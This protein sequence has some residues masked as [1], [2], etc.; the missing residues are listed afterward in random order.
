MI[1]FNFNPTIRETNKYL[2]E[3]VEELLKKHGQVSNE[4]FEKELVAITGISYKQVKNYKNDPKP[5]RRLKDNAIVLKFVRERRKKDAK[6]RA[7]ILGIKVMTI[8]AAIGF[9]IHQWPSKE[10]SKVYVINNSPVETDLK[11]DESKLQAA[12]LHAKI[13]LPK[14]GWTVKLGP[15][16]NSK[17]DLDEFDCKAV[18]SN[19]KNCEY[20]LNDNDLRFSFSIIGPIIERISVSTYDSKSVEVLERQALDLIQN[21][22]KVDNPSGTSSI[23]KTDLEIIQFEKTVWKDEPGKPTSFV[24]NA[25][26][27]L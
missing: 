10:D 11:L 5:N 21:F 12:D 23:Y 13:K 3:I 27:N 20:K 25:R 24:L 1:L 19:L 9:A 2:N 16:T 6:K 22:T 15:L 4:E 26:L 14:V 17:L 18:E 7:L 8:L